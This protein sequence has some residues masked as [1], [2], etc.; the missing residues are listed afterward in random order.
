VVLTTKI[1]DLIYG[2]GVKKICYCKLISSYPTR[3][4][5]LPAFIFSQVMTIMV[6]IPL[7]FTSLFIWMCVYL[8][9]GQ[10]QLFP[11]M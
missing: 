10:V 6:N 3:I 7:V 4:L 2:Q 8:H 1:C 5:E 11:R 9:T